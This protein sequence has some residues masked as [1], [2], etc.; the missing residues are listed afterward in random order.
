MPSSINFFV[1]DK[2]G[3]FQLALW[4]FKGQRRWLWH[5]GEQDIIDW[6]WM[7]REEEEE[8]IV[9]LA[10]ERSVNYYQFDLSAIDSSPSVDTPTNLQF[11]APLAKAKHSWTFNDSVIE[12]VS[13]ASREHFLV[14]TQKSL[15]IFKLNKS[16]DFNHETSLLVKCSQLWTSKS[17]GMA[18]LASS[19]GLSL[20]NCHTR[21]FLQLPLPSGLALPLQ[22]ALVGSSVCL[23]L[24]QYSITA[25]DVLNG[26]LLSHRRLHGIN[27]SSTTDSYHLTPFSTDFHQLCLYNGAGKLRLLSF[28]ADDDDGNEGSKQSFKPTPEPKKSPVNPASALLRQ[29]IADWKSEHQEEQALD[30]LRDK[31]NLNE[32]SEEQMLKLAIS[33]SGGQLQESASGSDVDTDLEIALR[34]SL[35]E[36]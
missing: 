16:T 12:Q 21:R 9:L 20:F 24:A 28:I 23:A 5:L 19:E 32:M 18:L 8:L 26:E 27:H 6:C 15:E 35:R 4:K 2:K 11:F 29:E 30:A 34:L 25:F 7:K 22:D 10:Q 13:F 33:L 3:Y 17:I 31:F 1:E 14:R 36:N